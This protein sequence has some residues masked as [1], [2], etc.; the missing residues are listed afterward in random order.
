MTKSTITLGTCHGGD[1]PICIR[2]KHNLIYPKVQKHQVSHLLF[3]AFTSKDHRFSLSVDYLETHS[4]VAV[5]GDEIDEKA[6][7]P[8]VQ[9]RGRFKVTSESVEM[10]KVNIQISF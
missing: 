6:K 5:N 8:V 3:R 9:Q 4:Y 10:E 7:N 1:I 2:Q